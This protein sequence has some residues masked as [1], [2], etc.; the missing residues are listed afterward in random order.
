MGKAEKEDLK[1]W[2][3]YHREDYAAVKDRLTACRNVMFHGRKDAA[4][5]MLKKSCVNAVFSIQTQRARHEEAFTLW[6]NGMS[7]EKAAAKTVYGT[8]KAEWLHYSLGTF[9]FKDA[10]ETLRKDGP[11]AALEKLEE[12]FKGLSWV[13]AAF[14]LAMTGVWEMA[15]PDT[16]TKQTLGIEHRISSR[17]RFNAALS[18]IDAALDIDE[19]LFIKQWVMYDFKEQEHARHMAFFNQVLNIQ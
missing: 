1:W 7:L 8:Q 19:P 11:V 6:C 10:V 9:R 17:D 4:A 16:R 13:K 18:D 12:W 5:E 3:E 14:A 15:C 2:Y